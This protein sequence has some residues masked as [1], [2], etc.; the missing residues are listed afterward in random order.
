MQAT[1]IRSLVVHLPFLHLGTVVFAAID[2]S[3]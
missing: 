3:P 2:L 1:P